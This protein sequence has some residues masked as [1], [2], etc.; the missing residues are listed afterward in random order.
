VVRLL[1]VNRFSGFLFTRPFI[2]WASNGSSNRRY[3]CLIIRNTKNLTV[4]GFL[5]SSMMQLLQVMW[6]LEK[7]WVSTGHFPT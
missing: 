4:I 7:Q 3:S 6:T 1:D 5:K 2:K